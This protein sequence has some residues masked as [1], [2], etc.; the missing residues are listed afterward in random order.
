MEAPV[1]AP[2]ARAHTERWVASVRR[3]CL[4]GILVVGHLHLQHVLATYVAHYNQHRPHRAL[5]Q[6]PLLRTSPPGDE[7]QIAEMINLDRP[8]VETYLA[9]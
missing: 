7:Q 3:G 9:G 4:D 8:A 5:A 6:R 1:Q 2:K